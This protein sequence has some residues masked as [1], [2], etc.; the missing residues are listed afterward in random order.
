[1]IRYALAD[2]SLRNKVNLKDYEDVISSA[3]LS[4]FPKAKFKVFEYCYEIYSP[5]NKGQIL[6]IGRTLAHSDLGKFCLSRP[7]LF[8][9]RKSK[10]E[11]D[12]S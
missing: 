10:R 8:V 4:V 6:K 7:I 9:G 1:M 12:N 11:G 2:A 5:I 3:I